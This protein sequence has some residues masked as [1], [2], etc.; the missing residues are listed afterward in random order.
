MFL[1][2]SRGLALKRCSRSGMRVMGLPKNVICARPIQNASEHERIAEMLKSLWAANSTF[3]INLALKMCLSDLPPCLPPSPTCHQ[4]AE[5]T[6][7][8]CLKAA[9]NSCVLPG[10]IVNTSQHTKPAVCEKFELMRK[11]HW[12][13][14]QAKRIRFNFHDHGPVSLRRFFK[15]ASGKCCSTSNEPKSMRPQVHMK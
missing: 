5:Q 3:S 8:A 14:M 10:P 15:H 2:L 13:N 1:H 4:K 7:I 12:L 6:N 9:R 11:T